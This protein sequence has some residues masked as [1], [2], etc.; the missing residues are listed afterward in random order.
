MRTTITTAVLLSLLSS[1]TVF[2]ADAPILSTSGKFDEATGEA[3]FNQVCQGCHMADGQ[4]SHGAGAYPALAANP[5]LGAKV[6][7]V[8]MVSSGQGGMPGF[9]KYMDDQQIAS[10]VNYVRTHFGNQYADTV[11]VEDVKTVTRR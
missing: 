5:K 7:P 11:T 9:Q 6:Y 1:A 3:L 8:Y 2:A 10:V 4:G